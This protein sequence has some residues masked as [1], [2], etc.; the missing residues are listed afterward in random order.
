MVR[1]LDPHFT[2]LPV[3]SPHFTPGLAIHV[4]VLHSHVY[5]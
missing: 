3:R 5:S 1:E 4:G 2:P